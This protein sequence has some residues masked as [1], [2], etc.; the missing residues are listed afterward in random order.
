MTDQP[1]ILCIY[2][3]NCTDGFGAAWAM[4]H[5][6]KVPIEFY[7]AVYGKEPPDVRGRCVYM[8]DFSYKRGI[9]AR[10]RV[11]SLRSEPGGADVSQMA[12]LYGGGGHFSAAGFTM[13]IGWEGDE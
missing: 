3:G 9:M 11:F 7:P 4:R 12:A 6:H 5:H 8:L 1:K 10:G 13:P 2:H